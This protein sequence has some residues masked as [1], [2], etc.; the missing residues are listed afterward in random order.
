M[1][2]WLAIAAVGAVSLAMPVWA[3]RH[4]GGSAGFGG[5]AGFASHGPMGGMRGPAI[6][7]RGF[8][9]TPQSGMRGGG[10]S[11]GGSFGPHPG[12]FPGRPFFHRRSHPW[13]YGYGYPGW[14]WYGGYYSQPYYPSDDY[15]EDYNA[16]ENQ[17]E[18][19]QQA[20]IDRLQEEVE[21]LREERSAQGLHPDPPTQWDGES[22]ATKLI[23]RDQHTEEI[24]NYAIVGQTLWIFTGDR[25]KKIMLAELDLPATKKANED[26]GVAFQ[27]P[28]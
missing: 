13:Y 6:A 24:Q 23:F 17:V 9:G 28:R 20:E 19:E 4:G 3:Q 25:T 11:H 8:G 22:E 12:F 2:R 16:R 27:I 15:S 5:H 21:R 18:Q 10:G 26:H 1:R 14:D 7:S